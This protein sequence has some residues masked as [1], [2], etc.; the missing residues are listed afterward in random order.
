MTNDPAQQKGRIIRWAQGLLGSNA[1][2]LDFETTGLHGSD[3]VQIGAVDMKGNTVYETLVK[4]AMPISVGAMGVHGITHEMVADAPTFETL[5]IEL[6]LLLAGRTVVAYNAPFDKGILLGVC[7]RRNL[8]VPRIKGWECAMRAYATYYFGG[9]GGGKWQSLSKA[10][11]QQGIR[12]ENA[13]SAIAD[14]KMTWQL[15][16]KMAGA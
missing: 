11:M 1:L 3:I 12:I 2:I 14:C 5:Y 9:R 7:H 10:C 13:H 15:M 8:P 16:K 4:P 6:S